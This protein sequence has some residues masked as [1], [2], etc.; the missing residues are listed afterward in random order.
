[1][2]MT[3]PTLDDV[4]YMEGHLFIPDGL[5]Y[6]VWKELGDHLQFRERNCS[7]WLGDWWRYGERQYGEA[8]SQAAPT[9]YAA[10]TLQNAARVAERIEPTRRREGSGVPFSYFEAVAALSPEKQ[11]VL[12]DEAVRGEMP[13]AE[14]REKVRHLRAVEDPPEDA[15]S[16]QFGC[17]TCGS[18]GPHLDCQDG[19]TRFD[20]G[21]LCGWLGDHAE[22]DV[23]VLSEQQVAGWRQERAG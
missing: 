23:R 1:M 17:A 12:L 14:L 18:T 8:S 22:H 9:G 3:V 11:D 2:T 5:P 10:K 16:Y 7:W 20:G 4:E 13:R 15:R 6:P 21:A 19:R